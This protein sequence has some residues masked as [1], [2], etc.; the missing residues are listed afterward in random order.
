MTEQDYKTKS[1]TA[2]GRKALHTEL[3]DII[4]DKMQKLTDG[5]PAANRD[6]VAVMFATAMDKMQ[7]IGNGNLFKF[8]AADFV[9]ARDFIR[10]IVDVNN[11][12]I[13]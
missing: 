2:E 3:L 8:F 6:K 7:T 10:A 13:W 9:T 4:K 11:N 5:A 1:S 12:K